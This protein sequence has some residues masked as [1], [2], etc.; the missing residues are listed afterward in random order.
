VKAVTHKNAVRNFKQ[1]SNAKLPAFCPER[2]Q[3]DR[4]PRGFRL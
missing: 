4:L 1:F 2:T 3:P